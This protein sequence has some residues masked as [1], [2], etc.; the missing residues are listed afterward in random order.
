MILFGERI[1]LPEGNKPCHLP[2]SQFFNCLVVA[3][4]AVRLVKSDAMNDVFVVGS[5][6]MLT[7]L[8][9]SKSN[10]FVTFAVSVI[11]RNARGVAMPVAGASVDFSVATEANILQ[12][13][14]W[15]RRRN[16][17]FC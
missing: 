10:E 9:V 13:L 2:D 3:G 15:R 6:R 14:N 7:K 16:A 8:G 17:C 1:I 4:P 11:K 12:S 5:E